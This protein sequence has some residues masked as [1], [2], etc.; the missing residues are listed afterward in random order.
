MRWFLFSA[1]SKNIEANKYKINVNRT[2]FCTLGIPEKVKSDNAT[3]FMSKEFRQFAV[4]YGFELENSSPH[5]P[6]GNGFA[7]RMLHLAK[8][9]LKK[10]D[11]EEGLLNYRSTPLGDGCSPAQLLMGKLR[12]N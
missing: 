10:G 7:E 11:L 6:Q 2:A 4:N 12:I 8:N 9:I 3:E 5:H 1:G